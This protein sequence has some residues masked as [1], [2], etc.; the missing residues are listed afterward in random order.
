MRLDLL[1]AKLER[2]LE[3]HDTLVALRPLLLGLRPLTLGEQLEPLACDVITAKSR[4]ENVT[5]HALVSGKALS[6]TPSPGGGE[7]DRRSS[8]RD[9]A[10][11]S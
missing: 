2:R 3:L 6:M 7:G 4:R 10:P 1:A 8:R 5:G 9:A 11:R